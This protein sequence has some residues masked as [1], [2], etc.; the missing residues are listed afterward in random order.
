M[1]KIHNEHICTTRISPKL[2]TVFENKSG[3]RRTAYS[4]RNS[5]ISNALFFSVFQKGFFCFFLKLQICYEWQQNEQWNVLRP[6]SIFGAVRIPNLRWRSTFMRKSRPKKKKCSKIFRKKSQSDMEWMETTGA[7]N[8]NKIKK[9][10]RKNP[11][12]KHFNQ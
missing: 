4:N 9:R 3:L 6:R 1:Y 5:S 7:R 8:S 10:K 11:G 12:R 2:F